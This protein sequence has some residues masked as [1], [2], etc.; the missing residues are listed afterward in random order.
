MA[1]GFGSA[2][3]GS[4]DP[5][6][7]P[8]IKCNLRKHKPNRKPRTPFTTQQLLSLEKK[9][10]EKQ[11]LSIAER[12]E[13]SSS[14]HLT[15]TQVKIWFQNRR[16]KA[17]RL[18]EAE[19]EK[20]KMAARPL[21]PHHHPHHHHHPPFG[22]L[23]HHPHHPSH[24]HHHLLAPHPLVQMQRHH[25][26][27]A[28]HPSQLPSPLGPFP[29]I[30]HQPPPPPSHPQQAHGPTPSATNPQPPHAASPATSPSLSA[31]S[32]IPSPTGSTG[33]S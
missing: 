13:F 11:Y 33:M 16:A 24:P 2:L 6:D 31:P 26:H 27:H 7:P 15:E 4:T 20:L 25:Q 32:P 29:G 8:K 5:N 18:Q 21:Y 23:P 3:G 28:P 12:A 10:R 1:G 22:L 30:C 17:K 19:L 9:F 14:L